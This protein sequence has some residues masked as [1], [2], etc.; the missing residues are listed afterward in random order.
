LDQI[1]SLII[2]IRAD[3][4]EVVYFSQS[5]P[6]TAVTAPRKPNCT[7]TEPNK[8]SVDGPRSNVVAFDR[9]RS[10]EDRR[11]L[12]TYLAQDRRSG[13]ADRRRKRRK[14]LPGF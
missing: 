8:K 10:I 3:F 14:Q 11:K 5:H 2:S 6:G 7:A 1:Q 13:I 9:R 12:Q 4:I